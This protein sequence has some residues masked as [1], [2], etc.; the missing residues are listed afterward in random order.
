MKNSK[1]I[2][3]YQIILLAVLTGVIVATVFNLTSH[4]L[5][6]KS[7]KEFIDSAIYYGKNLFAVSEE[8]VSK[9]NVSYLVFDDSIIKS[10]L[11]VDIEVFGYKFLATFELMVNKNFITPS[12]YNFGM[13]MSNLLSIF[14]LIGLPIVMFIVLY[15]V[16]LFRDVVKSESSQQSAPLKLF[17]KFKLQIYDRIKF[18]ILEL[19]FNLRYTKWL[20]W[21]Y[22][23][24]LL[25]NVNIVSLFLIV[26]AWYL[27][28]VFS[29][30]FLSIWYLIC[31]F[32]ICIS[33]LLRPIFWPAWIVLL[34]VLII[35]KKIDK[36]YSKLED[37]F[38]RNETFIQ[39]NFGVVTG[40]YGPPGTGKTTSA[41]AFAT[42]IEVMLRE[43]ARSQ[44]LEIRAEFPEFP[45][46][47][48]EEEI[49]SLKEESKCVN[50]IQIEF[51]FK[52]KFKKSEI[53]Y[54]Y[55]LRYNKN[56]HYDGLSVAYIKD[57]LNDY[58]QLYFIYIS[59]LAY[60][61]YSIRYDEGVELT[62]AFPGLKYNFFHRDIKMDEY[63]Q[64]NQSYHA[65]IFDYNLL[66]L[67]SQ[68]EKM[69][70]KDPK[71][72]TDAEKKELDRL[73]TLFDFGVITISEIAKERGNRDTNKNRDFGETNP[74][75][76]G[77]AN[78][79][80]LI[81]HLTTVRHQ[82]Y[83]F[84]IWD[85]QKISA[86][87]QVEAAMAEVNIFLPKQTR[88]RKNALPLWF[89]EGIVLEWGLSH[90]SNLYN[91]YIAHRNDQTLF[92]YYV[93][94]MY[95]FFYNLNRKIA[96]TFGYKRYDLNLSG[97]G[98]NGGQEQRGESTFYV[99]DKIVYSGK[100]FDT[101]V[102]SGYFDKLKLQAEEGNNQVDS[103]EGSTAS[104]KELERTHGYMF[105]EL[106]TTIKQYIKRNSDIKSRRKKE[107][108]RF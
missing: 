98:I 59:I 22:L 1:R 74:S 30:D 55:D 44:M 38:Y 47:Y 76:D 62:H 32:F 53:I 102:Y 15:Y 107:N 94:H 67:N 24:I 13:T 21:P 18:F 16:R 108:S 41:V 91:K 82:Q 48:L 12:W 36:G 8:T 100:K 10:L 27:Y 87:R 25:Y 33:P 88:N 75:N 106:G 7:G 11:P 3:V 58:A 56:C 4:R 71:D 29:M 42:Q 81:R 72:L 101:A 37:M 80:G 63:K 92:S 89:F 40:I 70:N 105:G 66:R 43:K 64:T 26:I 79:L 9:D 97:V 6:L 65:N 46:R 85:D 78:C 50:K 19:W 20:F 52:D 61:T 14:M 51:Y 35:K 17:L 60:S 84:I 104:F 34:F 96:N 57:E 69:Y 93:F 95:S 28:F 83:G 49:E 23:I 39:D 73:I 2:N 31:K 45:F 77:L 103:F 86:L 54:G 68:V 5:F 90:Y 99:M